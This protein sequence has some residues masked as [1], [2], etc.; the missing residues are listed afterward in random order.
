MRNRLR[1]LYLWFHCL[2][3]SDEYVPRLGQLSILV[4]PQHNPESS[5]ARH[6]LPDNPVIA[7]PLL[8]PLEKGGLRVSGLLYRAIGTRTAFG[9]PALSQQV[10][11]EFPP[12]SIS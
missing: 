4:V 7:G 8:N 6:S 9:H 3:P 1:R 11:Y 5:A 2:F 12:R 10:F